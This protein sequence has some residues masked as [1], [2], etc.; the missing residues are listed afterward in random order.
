[1]K[2]APEIGST[3]S[4]PAIPLVSDLREREP[5]FIKHPKTVKNPVCL[6]FKSSVWVRQIKIEGDECDAC[7]WVR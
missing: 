5:P 3:S 7:Q 6:P 1:M 4:R 2:R